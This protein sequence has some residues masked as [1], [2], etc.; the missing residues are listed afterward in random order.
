VLASRL[1]NGVLDGTEGA[2]QSGRGRD[3]LV[4]GACRHHRRARLVRRR[5]EYAG[6][7]N[8]AIVQTEDWL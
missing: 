4:V 1:D 3:H 8:H 5:A 2:Q 6:G 7:R